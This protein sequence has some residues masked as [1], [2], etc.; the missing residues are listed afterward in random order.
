MVTEQEVAT[1]EEETTTNEPSSENG[2]IDDEPLRQEGVKAL[3]AWKQR[4]K[5]A[6]RE[7]KRA[8]ELESKLAQF[9]EANKTEQEKLLEKARKEA[10][11][12]ARNEIMS[13]VQRERLETSVVRAATGKLSDPDDAVRFLD[14]DDL[15][16]AD[17]GAISA[18]IDELLKTKPYL[19]G[20]TRP[21]GDADQGVRGSS[22]P[23]QLTRDDLKTM[24]P[25]QIEQARAEGQLDELLGR[26]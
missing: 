16:D 7:A 5:E 24:S 2:Q 22:G 6:E 15:T 13:Q 8:K 12:E 23:K 10:A 9:E 1:T 4:A 3:Q 20:A 11:D 21:V 19:A 26:K 14:L 25:Q 17:A 18:A